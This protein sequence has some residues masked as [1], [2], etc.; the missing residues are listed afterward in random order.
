MFADDVDVEG[1]RERVKK[2]ACRLNIWREI[3]ES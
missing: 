1:E 2:V 3:M